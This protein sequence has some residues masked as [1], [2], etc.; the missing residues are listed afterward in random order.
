MVDATGQLKDCGRLE[1]F[2]RFPWLD[3]LRGKKPKL[4]SCKVLLE[5][6]CC[7]MNLISL[8]ERF[9]RPILTERL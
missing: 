2:L 4:L 5:H 7:S 9:L 8:S 6:E 3:A 1:G